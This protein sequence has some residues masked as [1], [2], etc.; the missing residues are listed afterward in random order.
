MLN[1][2]ALVELCRLPN[3][4][5]ALAD[6]MMGFLVTHA[7]AL[8]GP[9]LTLLGAASCLIYTAGMVLND[10]FDV[11]I[12]RAERPD[13]PLPSGRVSVPL[14][15]A[16]GLGLLAAGVGCA[17][18]AAAL[19]GD[20]RPAYV[21][22]GLAV[23]VLAYDLVLKSTPLGPLAMGGCRA[24]NVLLGMSLSETPWQTVHLIV[25]G[26][27]GVY[28]VGV[29]WFARSE[30]EESRAAPLL[31]ALVV[32]MGAFGFLAWLPSFDLP[33]G[34]GERRFPYAA[35]LEMRW[36]LVWLLLASSV[37]LRC[38][39]AMQVPSPRNVQRAIVNCLQVIIVIDALVCFAARDV[40]VSLTVLVLLAPMTV[41][42]RWLYS[43]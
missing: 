15:R 22:A 8:G 37:A 36:H 7:T 39:R 40:L 24:L 11:E 18:G 5:T 23:L 14:A 31:G 20:A 43:T 26:G 19:A 21:V 10:V 42:G 32:M 4:F 27:M 28:I 13:R 41:L 16:L 2:R 25:A 38:V 30:A 35:L 3:V 1:F 17:G 34:G 29:S 9:E 33:D 12:D 6:V